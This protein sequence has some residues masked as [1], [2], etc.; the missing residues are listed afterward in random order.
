MVIPNVALRRDYEN[1]NIVELTVGFS[2]MF[3][4]N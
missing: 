3:K 2:V 1:I 4:K